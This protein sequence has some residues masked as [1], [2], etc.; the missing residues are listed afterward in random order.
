MVWGAPKP[1][2][3]WADNVEEEEAAVAVAPAKPTAF[4]AGAAKIKEDDFPDLAVAAKVKESKKDK[5][6]KAAKQTLSLTD[7]LK[8]DVG[9][10]VPTAFGASRRLGASGGGG[11]DVD[12][13]SLPTAP[14]PRAEGEESAG[15]MGGGFRE[16][17]GGRRGFGDDDR[18][19]DGDSED[20]GPSRADA[21]DSWGADRKSMPSDDRGRGGFGGGGGGGFREREGGFG[22]GGGFRDRSRE[23]GFGDGPSRADEVDNWGTKKSF[24]PSSSTRGGFEDRPRAGGFG[25]SFRDRSPG[26][27]RDRSPGGFREPSKADTEERWGRAS[28]G[29]FKPTAFEDRPRREFDDRPPRRGG[30]GFGDRDTSRDGSRDGRPPLPRDNS[31]DRVW[32]REG[33]GGG[34]EEGAPRERPRLNLAPRSAAPAGEGASGGASKAS[35][36]GAARPREEVLKEQGRDAVKEDLK[37]EHE[38]ADRPETA[39]EKALKAEMANLQIR[40][41]AG[42]ADAEFEEEGKDD[43][44]AE[45]KEGGSTKTVAQA[46]EELEGRLSKLQL[47]L[48]AKAKYARAAGAGDDPS[49]ERAPRREPSPA[50]EG[51][52]RRSDANGAPAPR[53][54]RDD[55]ARGRSGYEDAPPRSRG[56]EDRPRGGGHEDRGRRDS[57]P[58]DTPPRD[59]APREAPPRATSRDDKPR[60]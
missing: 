56:F 52:W 41:E 3:A 12:V 21:S 36:F 7:F 1:A 26:A 55:A 4:V 39:E 58:R 2:G 5:K 38:A 14:R 40:V 27:A 31:Q 34:G 51:G 10:G 16:Y 24:V 13:R 30:F 48:D 53:G 50:A 29:D 11:G 47:E 20:M 8:S 28:G 25:G 43:E 45:E 15:P 32:R 44:E 17:G 60:W 49:R 22:G 54:F 37:Y 46:L 6:K 42:E 59:S 35:V 57:V 33:G 23:G 9:G 18:R 19:R